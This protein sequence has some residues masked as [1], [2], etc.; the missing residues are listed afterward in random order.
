MVALGNSSCLGWLHWADSVLPGQPW[1][2]DHEGDEEGQSLYKCLAL[3]LESVIATTW[4]CR[5]PAM[6]GG[7]GSY[8]YPTRSLTTG[9]L[10]GTW[11]I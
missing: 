10:K 8:S 9:R 4:C 1:G 11:S 7:L 6:P 2:A 3:Y 5:G